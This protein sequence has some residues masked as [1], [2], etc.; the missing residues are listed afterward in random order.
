MRM[1]VLA[2]GA[3]LFTSPVLAQANPVHLECEMP[4]GKW[5]I[6]VV[7]SD[8]RVDYKHS[9]A[10]SSVKAVFAGSTITWGP[11]HFRMILDRETLTLSRSGVVPA[12]GKCTIVTR[13]RA[14]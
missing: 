5:E 3:L 9:M 13:K 7:E 14:F 1:T 10:T 11:E 8:G 6:T 12:V 2:A 4:A